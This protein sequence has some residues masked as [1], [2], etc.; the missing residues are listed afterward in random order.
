MKYFVQRGD[1]PS[2]DVCNV[3]AFYRHITQLLFLYIILPPYFRPLECF[4][5]LV[6][7]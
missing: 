3:C 1:N 4:L 6:S 5:R 2:N 7:S